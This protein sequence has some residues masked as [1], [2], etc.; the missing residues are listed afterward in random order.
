MALNAALGASQTASSFLDGLDQS[1]ASGLAVLKADFTLAPVLPQSLSSMTGG[2]GS[3]GQSLRQKT[4]FPLG[5]KSLE[6]I[7]VAREWHSVYPTAETWRAAAVRNCGGRAVKIRTADG[8]LLSALWCRANGAVVTELAAAAVVFHANAMLSLDMAEY[9]KWYSREC[10]MS[11]LLVTIGG[12]GDSEGGAG[13]P[14]ELSTYLDADAAL[15]WLTNYGLPGLACD[16]VVAHGL[17]IGGALAAALA[18]AHRGVHLTLDQTFVNAVE[19]WCA[20][21]Y[22]RA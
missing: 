21:A 1:F 20:H 17:S 19:V 22:P 13:T 14:S 8:R 6:E 12:Y 4:F 15:T 2:F 10:G 18:E 3:I 7:L 11:A 5:G 16:R 9:A